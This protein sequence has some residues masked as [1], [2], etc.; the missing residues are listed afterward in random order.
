VGNHAS[1]GLA[2][3]GSALRSTQMELP[4]TGSTFQP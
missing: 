2:N 1:I 4:K 3:A